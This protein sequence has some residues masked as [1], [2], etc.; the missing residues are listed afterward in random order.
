MTAC[1]ARKAGKCSLWKSSHIPLWRLGW[2]FHKRKRGKMVIRGN[3][4]SHQISHPNFG[5][6]FSFLIQE[7]ILLSNDIIF[8]WPNISLQ[9]IWKLFLLPNILLTMQSLFCGFEETPPAPK[10]FSTTWLSGLL[11]FPFIL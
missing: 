6:N 3:Y 1:A 2:S 8:L 9:L 7:L 5:K 4:K 11:K 10:Y